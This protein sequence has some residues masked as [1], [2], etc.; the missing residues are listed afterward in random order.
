MRRGIPA[1]LIA[2]ALLA[3]GSVLM[4]RWNAST[5]PEEPSGPASR[6]P[7]EAVVAAAAGDVRVTSGEE[8]RRAETG[9]TI[10]PGDIIETGTDGSVSLEF[11]AGVRVGLDANTRVTVTDARY[12][13]SSWR[14]Q[15]VRLRFE[16]GRVWS[17]A[18]KL[19]DLDSTYELTYADVVTNVRGTAYAMTGRGS[20]LAI[21]EFDGSI[22]VSGRANGVL[23]EGFS[24]RIDP[25]NPPRDL[26]SAVFPT[27]DEVRNDPWIRK[28]LAADA[29]FAKRAAEIRRAYG[30][31]DTADGIGAE[32]GPYT[33]DSREHSNFRTV[34]VSATDGSR[35]VAAGSSVGLSA[36]AVF[37]EPAGER[38]EDVTTRAAWQISDS[39]LGMIDA[40][41]RLTVKP[42]SF[43]MITIVA[44]W[45]D[46]THEHSGFLTLSI[47]SR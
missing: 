3:S 25:G 11:F 8:T 35:S 24:L 18:L 29:S 10:L 16:A 44:R 30:S 21:D 20:D 9:R 46:G 39:R 19:L 47:G 42:E 32:A 2:L 41:G 13:P 7:L 5:A 28:Q 15:T 4:L 12:D 26:S 34:R 31:D 33:L 1:F 45:N 40:N 38:M 14:K 22:Q 6:P 23:E 17:R 43:G 27:P 36:V 37:T